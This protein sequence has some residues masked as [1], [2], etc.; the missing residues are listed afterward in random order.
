[1]CYVLKIKEI[2]NLN[3]KPCYKSNFDPKIFKPPKLCS[4][5]FGYQISQIFVDS[6]AKNLKGW[7]DNS[8]IWPVT[9]VSNMRPCKEI[10]FLKGL[11]Q[12]AVGLCRIP[13]HWQFDKLPESIAIPIGSAAHCAR[14]HISKAAR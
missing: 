12:C 13:W 7:S 4:K 1:M 8:K 9:H 2:K 3:S 5:Y 10:G 11:T 6:F 14:E